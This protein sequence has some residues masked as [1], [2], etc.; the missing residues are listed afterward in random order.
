MSYEIAHDNL[1]NKTP[2]YQMAKMMRK[3]LSE[4]Q[5]KHRKEAVKEL[6]KLKPEELD[7]IADYS[8]SKSETNV[9][10]PRVNS[11]QFIENPFMLY[12]DMFKYNWNT[13]T[14]SWYQNHRNIAV[15]AR[16]P[17]IESVKSDG[18]NSYQAALNAAVT[19]KVEP[20]VPVNINFRPGPPINPPPM[21][22]PPVQQTGIF[23]NLIII[24]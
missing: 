8:I 20:R 17:G 16:K 4:D 18:S 14:N 1:A 10:P 24:L 15:Y 22:T 11:L 9:P 3:S 6:R 2:I 7:T 23:S 19:P 13:M 5:I 21:S 12:Q